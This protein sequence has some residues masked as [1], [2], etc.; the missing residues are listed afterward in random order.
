LRVEDVPEI[1]LD[2]RLRPEE[3]AR[4]EQAAETTH[5]SLGSFVLRAA[6]AEADRVLA[7]ADNALTVERIADKLAAEYSDALRLLGGS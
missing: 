3:L 5:E 2:L 4:I 7:H 6:I 1:R